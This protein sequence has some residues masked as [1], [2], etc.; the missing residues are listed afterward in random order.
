MFVC[1]LYKAGKTFLLHLLGFV[2]NL[3][4]AVPVCSESQLPFNELRTLGFVP[5]INK[6]PREWL[7][8]FGIKDKIGIMPMSEEGRNLSTI[9]YG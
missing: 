1:E 8:G 7:R 6:D 5:E 3:P 4:L 2:T 9:K